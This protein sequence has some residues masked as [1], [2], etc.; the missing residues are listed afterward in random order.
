MASMDLIEQ[1]I[2]GLYEEIPDKIACTKK[3]LHLA[4]KT[5]NMEQ[6]MANGILFQKF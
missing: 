1:Y 3:I 2:E 6:L 4:R 5:E